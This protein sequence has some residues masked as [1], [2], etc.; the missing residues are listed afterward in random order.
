M[1]Q[2]KAR[3][4]AVTYIANLSVITRRNSRLSV[5]ENFQWWPNWLPRKFVKTSQN[6]GDTN[7]QQQHK[8]VSFS[9]MIPMVCQYNIAQQ[10][11]RTVSWNIA[12][13]NGLARTSHQLAVKSN[14]LEVWMSN[15]LN[16]AI[17]CAL[18]H[19]SKCDSDARLLDIGS[20]LL[21]GISE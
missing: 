12:G 15:G 10:Y 9:A 6:C 7:A 8:I 16:V 4:L 19:R 5:F 21:L 3:M 14:P 20:R 1:K 13:Q 11:W 2:T 17:G 18:Q